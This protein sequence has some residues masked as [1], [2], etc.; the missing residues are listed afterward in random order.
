MLELVPQHRTDKGT[1]WKAIGEELGI[2]PK[3]C[4]NKYKS[5]QYSDMKLGHFTAEEDALI[6]QRVKEWGDKG[7]G[8][9]VALEKEMDRA[10]V[11]IRGRW[12][13]QRDLN[14]M[15]WTDEMVYSAYVV[16]ITT[17]VMLLLLQLFYFIAGCAPHRGGGAAQ[18]TGLGEGGGVHGGWA[19]C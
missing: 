8:L 12:L 13:I 16:S 5:I 3:D 11:N 4:S 14:N 15:H 17:V 18:S 10:G 1:D 6:C 2:V 7:N 19:Q 9:W